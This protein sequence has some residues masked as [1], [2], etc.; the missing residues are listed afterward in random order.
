M[1]D[2]GWMVD[3]ARR[4]SVAVTVEVLE[5][6]LDRVA[7][8]VAESGDKGLVYLPIYDRLETELQVLKAREDRMTRIRARIT[9]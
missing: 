9:R 8:L 3:R 6:C 4:T 1:T 7:R 5:R 2:H